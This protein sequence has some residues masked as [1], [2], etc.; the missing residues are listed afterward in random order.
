MNP[1]IGRAQELAAFARLLEKPVASLV[2]CQGRRRIGKSRFVAEGAKKAAHFLSF[3]GLPP[4]EGLAR[5]DQL[6]AFTSQLAAQSKAPRLALD[7]WPAAF[8]LLASQIP[9]TGSAVVLLDEISWMGIGD[10]DFAGHLKSAWDMHFSSR[11]SLVLV[12]CGSVSSWIQRN[13]LN[14]TAFVGRCSW[15]FFL[16]PLPLPECALFWG[17]RKISP[18]E[19]LRILAVTGGVPKYLEEIVPSKT[20][21]QNIESLCFHPGGILFNEFD[22]IF[23]DIFSRRAEAYRDIVRTL[24]SGPQTVQQVSVALGSGRG[25]SLSAALADLEGAGFLRKD[26]AFDPVSGMSRPR[27]IRFRLSDNYLRFYLKYV[28]PVRERVKKGLFQYSP[29]ESLQA[30]DTIMGLAFENLVLGS[31]PAVMDIVGLAN[32]PVLNAGPYSQSKTQRH[33]GCQ[34]D[35]LLRTSQSLY[36][37]ETK[38]RKQIPKKVIEEMKEKVTRLHTPRGLSVRTGLIYE[39]ELDP[40]IPRSDYFDFLI[41]A[42]DLLK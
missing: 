37:F 27:E 13:I 19:K 38:F 16:Q 39:G 6:N 18:A 31:L 11:P 21:E 2:T 28:E 23:H 34:I 42:G 3:T 36:V 32:V 29:L 1:F 8:Q 41:P 33:Q 40:E 12:L 35:I 24:V 30:W 26:V 25:G 5:Q 4:R 15:Q 9:A 14:S 7:S 22:S 20:A 10:P 17:R